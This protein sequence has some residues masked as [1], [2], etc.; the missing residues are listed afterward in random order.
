MSPESS[1]RS[2][3]SHEVS[4]R[5]R[6]K[7]ESIK[8][9]RRKHSSPSRDRRKSNSPEADIDWNGSDDEDRKIEE[10]RRRRKE[11]NE[12][13][14][15]TESA[16]SSRAAS[17]LLQL[18]N[19]DNGP[20]T[21]T[22]VSSAPSDD[23]ETATIVSEKAKSVISVSES[24]IETPGNNEDHGDF[25]GDLKEKLAHVKNKDVDK[26]I[27]KAEEQAKIDADHRHDDEV[28]RKK[29]EMKEEVQSKPAVTTFDMFAEDD[30]LPP[31]VLQNVTVISQ[32]STNLSL[33][34]NWDDT[35]GY[36]RVRIGEILDGRYRVY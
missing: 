32:D 21:I 20:G 36:Y 9:K 33:K 11:R 28:N 31:E 27:H 5:S 14:K 19:I 7:S 35:E 2:N 16:N 18:E 34:D 13:L 25:F 17:E 23:D 30:E 24:R 3:D 8:K 15:K 4:S 29:I 26:I 12:L 6:K 10:L 22:S 1:R